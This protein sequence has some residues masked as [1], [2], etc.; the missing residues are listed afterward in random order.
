M[1]LTLSLLIMLTLS[2]PVSGV[3]ASSVN[4]AIDGERVSVSLSLNFFQDA[5]ATP[6]L[7]GTFTGLSAENLT[8]ALNESLKTKGEAFSVP[9]V[10]GELKSANGWVNSTIQF[11]IAGAS[12]KKG[13][14]LV[15]NCS[16]ISFSVSRDLRLGNLSYNWIGATYVKPEFEKYVDY[17]TTPMNETIDEVI[18]SSGP[19]II[20]PKA[21]VDRAEKAVLLDF[22][23]LDEPVEYWKR[24][25][26]LVDGSTTFVYNPP[27]AVDLKMEVS[28]V[29]APPFVARAFY[30]YN[31]SVTVV[32]FAQ[33]QGNTINTDISAGVDPLFM[34]AVVLAS[35][36]VAVVASWTYRS[37]RRQFVRRRK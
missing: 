22:S 31:A 6:S 34:L 37:R 1:L 3:H 24:T 18:Y 16:W 28:R 4:Y 27:P 35:F 9:S 13:D 20:A 33:A 23:D 8:L 15:V 7:N 17:Q 12:S 21:A 30:S 10:A 2:Y 25:F 11:E 19:D 32:G 26:N 36:V 5:A 14:L 29:D